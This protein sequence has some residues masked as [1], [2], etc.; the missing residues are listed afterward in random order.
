MLLLCFMFYSTNIAVMGS[1]HVLDLL[2]TATPEYCVGNCIISAISRRSL[3]MP[4]GS[5]Q[6]N[7]TYTR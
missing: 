2:F 7:A 5:Q 1:E 3:A 4:V 6:C